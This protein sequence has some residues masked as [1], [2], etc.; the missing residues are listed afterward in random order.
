M[1]LRTGIWWPTSSATPPL[2]GPLPLPTTWRTPP[3]S[4]DKSYPNDKFMGPMAWIVL[5]GCKVPLV[6]IWAITGSAVIAV[7]VWICLTIACIVT[8]Q[9]F[10]IPL[11]RCA[12]SRLYPASSLRQVSPWPRS[13]HSI[14]C[15]RSR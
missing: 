10:E 4:L 8:G 6:I 5:V 14:G 11:K 9:V 1:S 13:R 3:R 2:P 7:D 15:C 12:R